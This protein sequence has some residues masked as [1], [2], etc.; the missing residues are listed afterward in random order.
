MYG[1][2]TLVMNEKVNSMWEAGKNVYHFGFGESR[3]PVHPVMAD[4][5]EKSASKH[6]YVPIQ[7]IKDLRQQVSKFYNQHFNL[8]SNENQIIVGVGSKSLLYAVIHSLPGDV[9]LPVPAWVSYKDH[10]EL[11]NRQVITF[12][13]DRGNGFQV[14]IDAL[15]KARAQATPG[16]CMLVLTNPN[17]PTGT[18]LSKENI[19]AVAEYCRKND[20]V[21][22]SDEIYSL[23]THDGFTHT[24]P[25]QYYPEGTVVLGGLS[26]I[27]S[28]G[29]WRMGVAVVP[30]GEIGNQII[31]G[32]RH[33]AGSIWSCVPAPIQYAS[34]TAYEDSSEI[35]NYIHTCG[36]MHQIRTQYLYNQMADMGIPC[37][38]PQGAF[39]LYPN[40]MPWAESLKSKGVHSDHELSLHLLEK[41]EIAVLGG[42]EFLDN[43]DQYAVR[44]AT[45]YIDA[46]SDEAAATLVR[47]YQQNPNPNSFI[48][49]HHP[50]F[51][52]M[53]QRLGDF[54]SSVN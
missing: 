54:I 14:S 4:A 52:A 28:L 33:I 16:P 31:D 25:A 42:S 15:A 12:D 27:L 29:G 6:S 26:K 38:S 30:E 23:L 49:D 2:A 44:L 5:L 43:P 19:K 37:A 50:R 1:S 21:I 46:E 20:I 40:F 34:I 17:N 8:T 35:K 10:A 22:L 7:G 9:I 53:V 45:S 48:Q 36:A 3:F 32:F 13:L 18:I 24:T 41:Y 47:A 51:K 11:N 39:Y